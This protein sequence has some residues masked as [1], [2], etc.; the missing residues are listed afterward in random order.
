M[1]QNNLDGL[2]LMLL[3]DYVLQETRTDL[4]IIVIGK[5][6]GAMVF[7]RGTD[8]RQMNH[9]RGQHVAAKIFLD[10]AHG[11]FLANAA[12]F[13]R[14][15]RVAR[16]DALE[17]Q[18]GRNIINGFCSIIRSRG[19]AGGQFAIDP[20]RRCR[21]RRRRAR[22][23]V[24]AH[25]DKAVVVELAS[26]GLEVARVEV[27]WEDLLCKD[28][29][30]VQDQ[31]ATAPLHNTRFIFCRQ[32]VVQPTH[33]LV[34]TETRSLAMAIS[35]NTTLRVLLGWQEHGRFYKSRRNHLVH[36]FASTRTIQ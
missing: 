6:L 8:L 2:V 1:L 25:V 24:G 11:K 17:Q 23:V 10:R 29:R 18:D 3:V 12:T 27:L 13:G 28:V 22:V 33:E 30:V 32:H 4:V 34:E 20:E 14:L 21:R 7:A 5:Q 35:M 31:Q 26:K 15:G 9:R 36:G 16:L 19:A